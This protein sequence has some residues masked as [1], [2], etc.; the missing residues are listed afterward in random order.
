MGETPADRGEQAPDEAQIADPTDGT[1]PEISCTLTDE[2][3][4][5]RLEWVSDN[6]IPH[7]SAIEER[8][9]GFTFVFDRTPEAYA[10]V[11]EVAWKES[12]CCAWATFEVELPPGDGPI[13]WHERS[14]RDEGAELFGDA[15]QDIN[16]KLDGVP[17]IT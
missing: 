8:D 13:K 2:E 16:E 1:L 14:D 4:E 7:L 11:A 6:L 5:Q 9:D 10:A 15:L 12:Q 3:A 17:S